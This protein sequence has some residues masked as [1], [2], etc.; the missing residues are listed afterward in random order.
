MDCLKVR[1]LINAYLDD[2]LSEVETRHVGTHVHECVSCR[3]ELEAYRQTRDLM[4]EFGRVDSPPNLAENIRIV[5]EKE[6]LIPRRRKPLTRLAAPRMSNLSRLALAAS[7]LIALLAG[8]SFYAYD[9]FSGVA[10]DMAK[11]KALHTQKLAQSQ[12][13]A[14]ANAQA[15]AK[16]LASV[17]EDKSPDEPEEITLSAD[18]DDDTPAASE[19][20]VMEPAADASRNAQNAFIFHDSRGSVERSSR[21]YSQPP[22]P[23]ASGA[24]SASRNEAKEILVD[25]EESGAFDVFSRGPGALPSSSSF[26]GNLDSGSP[27]PAMV[28]D[29]K[30][31]QPD[32]EK[33][34]TAMADMAWALA[35]PPEPARTRGLQ[36]KTDGTAKTA[37]STAVS[38]SGAT[39][40]AGK[41]KSKPSLNIILKASSL[42]PAMQQQAVLNQLQTQ[43][44]SGQAKVKDGKIVLNM[45]ADETLKVLNAMNADPAGVGRVPV[46]EKMLQNEIKGEQPRS[47]TTEIIFVPE[48]AP[49][50][51]A[52]AAPAATDSEDSGK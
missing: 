24:R 40:D 38:G 14:A 41:K 46:P 10:R 30:L 51:P 1:E 31:A 9:Y 28:A 16:K 19:S 49:A 3:H 25:E 52:E 35:Q 39:K 13:P 27:A 43:I 42:Q 5:M 12:T 6:R 17:P 29:S 23:R 18:L 20:A 15:F 21:G 50:K 45:S 4:R 34:V 44:Q 32:G 37:T 2:E 7:F 47:V 33:S 26:A 48:A 22:A 36:P 8:G 11:Q